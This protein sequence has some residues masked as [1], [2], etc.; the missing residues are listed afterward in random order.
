[1]DRSESKETL[2]KRENRRGGQ[3]VVRTDGRVNKATNGISRKRIRGVIRS[4]QR[5]APTILTLV[6][7]LSV[8]GYSETVEDRVNELEQKVRILERQN[9]VAPDTVESKAKETTK[10]TASAEGYSLKSA[11]GDFVFR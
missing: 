5:F 4:T 10:P 7:L 6:T 8:C 1:M 3:P 11:D 2:V 9:E